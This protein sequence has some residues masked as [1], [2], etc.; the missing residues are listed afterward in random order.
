MTTRQV[1]VIEGKSVPISNLDKVLWPEVGLTKTHLLEYYA[2]LYPYLQRH[3]QGRALTVTRYPH[4]VDGE[5]FYQKNVPPVHLPGFKCA[6]SRTS[7][8]WWP[9]IWLPLF[10]S[11]TLEP[12]NFTLPPIWRL[13]QIPPPMLLLTWIPPLQRAL[14]TPW[15]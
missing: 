4:G 2:R 1:V 3:W 7:I 5:F 9:K 11:P 10:G 15:R 12:S 8:M 13:D 14:P 6:L